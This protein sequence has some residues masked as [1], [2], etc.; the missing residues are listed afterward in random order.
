VD[1]ATGDQ[2]V[3]GS[4]KIIDGYGDVKTEFMNYTFELYDLRIDYF[5]K[6]PCFRVVRCKETIG[7]Q[8]TM[9]LIFE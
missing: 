8:E 6:K 5:L 9:D 3:I 7:N 4:K 2:Y 1:R